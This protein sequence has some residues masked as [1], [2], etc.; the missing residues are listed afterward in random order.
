[1]RTW[2]PFVTALVT[3]V[4]LTVTLADPPRADAA[5]R[6]GTGAGS[7]TQAYLVDAEPG[8]R[9]RL[10]G[11]SGAIAGGG[12]VDRLGSF[13]V[14][15][16][17]PGPGYR[18]EVAGRAGN[19]FAVLS[20]QPPDRSLYRGQRFGAGYHY[21]RMRDGVE[22]AVMV[23]LPVGATM[24]DGPFPT[25]IEYS[26]YQAAA[27]GD[28]AVGAVRE[29][30]GDADPLAASVGVILGGALAPAAGFA[31]VVVQMR[32]SGCSGGAFD[33]FDYP[34]IYDGYD[35]VEIVAGQPWVAGNKVGMVG[36]S[37]S[38]I[39][40]LSVAGTRPPGLAAIAPMSITDD[41]YSTGFPGGIFNTGFANSWITERQKDARP[42]PDGGQPYARELVRRG[43]RRC[44]NNQKLRL[45][46]QNI[47]RL[48]EENPTRTPSLLDHRSPSYWASKVDVP[49]LLTGA[50]QDE[51]VGAQ[52][53]SI[54]DEFSGKDDV[55][56]KMINGPHL[57]SVAPQLL[58]SWYEFLN[59]FVAKRVPRFS[60]PLVALAPVVY[61]ASTSTPGTPVRTDRLAGARDVDDA[62]RR[63]ARDPRIQVWFDSG[64]GSPVPGNISA[65]WQRGFAAWPP[66]SVGSGTRL[67]LAARGRLTEAKPAEGK[68]AA[69]RAPSSTVSLRPDPGSRPAGT[70][71]AVGASQV[72]WQGLP[73]YRWLQ[74]PGRSGLGFISTANDHDV[75][76]VGPASLD[77]LL[78]SSA[79]DTDLQATLSEVRPDGRETYVT[80]GQLRASF[81]D[82]TAASTVFEPR[83]NWLNPRRLRAGFQSVRIALNPVAHVFRKG[84]RIRITIT[85]PGG[86]MASWRFD[87]P[88]TGGRIV[89]TIALGPGGSSLVLPVVPGGRAGAPLSPCGGQRG[90]PCRVYRPAF[91]GG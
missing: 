19:T 60:A 78:A 53:T 41:L 81:R 88:A 86:D 72:P 70:L 56:V 38:G 25:V 43:D 68:P 32:G 84:S 27:P 48:I 49:V 23:R 18:F 74:A 59:I 36:I 26:G 5:V 63:F 7:V 47:R 22:L 2:V 79:G 8:A 87:T 73:P 42:A 34:T 15:E 75:L 1:M 77:L 44:L 69:G 66:A 4:L 21:V 64:S 11:P 30:L 35:I 20:G 91:N 83:R 54:I 58:G 28:V 57:D 71:N 51:Q 10:I 14:R 16:L 3:A 52:W 90:R 50:L 17:A 40:Q 62:R 65:H 46:T 31:T 82:V 67:T 89:D 37:F 12:R 9:V 24:A 45:R 33:L 55:W 6:T 85:A 61:G 39:S 29:R 80:T 76:V 13:L